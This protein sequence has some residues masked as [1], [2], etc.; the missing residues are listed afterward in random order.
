MAVYRTLEVE[1]EKRTTNLIVDKSAG[2]GSITTGAS[3]DVP[4]VDFGKVKKVQETE[5]S[6]PK[7]HAES[8]SQQKPPESQSDAAIFARE[9]A[10]AYEQAQLLEHSY[11]GKTSLVRLPSQEAPALP[12]VPVD[13]EHGERSQTSYQVKL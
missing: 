9:D 1:P 7:Y 11:K 12:H 5:I 6:A 13:L 3:F 8:F 4:L 10:Q 2:S